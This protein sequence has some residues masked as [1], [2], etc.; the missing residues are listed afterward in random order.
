MLDKKE[1]T[2]WC[3]DYAKDRDMIE[4]ALKKINVEP[5]TRSYAIERLTGLL[6]DALEYGVIVH[7]NTT[8][9]DDRLKYTMKLVKKLLS[10]GFS[11]REALALAT[12]IQTSDAHVQF[13]S[14]ACEVDGGDEE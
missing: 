12:W 14:T 9:W 11:R 3:E 1:I 8:I 13:E 7:H 10:E 2:K 4:N 5:T 6:M